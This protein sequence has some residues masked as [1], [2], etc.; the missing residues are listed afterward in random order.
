MIA[1]TTFQ[2]HPDREEQ[3]PFRAVP[4]MPTPNN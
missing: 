1:V 2:D 3:T 4:L